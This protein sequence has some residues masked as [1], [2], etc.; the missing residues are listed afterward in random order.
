[1]TAPAGSRPSSRDSA[2]RRRPVDRVVAVDTGSKRRQR[3]PADARPSGRSS[4][5]PGVDVV[6]RGG[7]PRAGRTSATRV[8]LAAPRRLAAR[9]PGALEALL[10]AAAPTPTST[11]SAPSSAS[12]PRCA[13]CSSSASR[14]A[15]PAAARPAS[16]A[17]STT[18]ASTT[19]CA[20]S[21]RSTPP[22]CW[23][24]GRCWTSSA[25]STSSCRSS[26]TTS[27][28]AGAP[29]PPATGPSWSRRRWSSTS[30]PRTAACRRTPLTGRHI[31]YQERRA[32]LYTL[33]VNASG[34]SLPWRVLRLGLG[35]LVRMIGLLL[36]RQVGAGTRRA[37]RAGLA[38]REPAPAPRRPAQAEGAAG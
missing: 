27:T 36:V 25:A 22:G 19:R 9:T 17:G 14:S 5:A 3:S 35:T 28:S 29:P 4:T 20:R 10:A 23:S 13:G 37:R 21:S 12:G 15:A 33:L 1:M 7:R 6:P 16:S 34:R 30:R 8:D 2:D 24:A 31:H 26:A 38:L 11:S 18:R 32:A